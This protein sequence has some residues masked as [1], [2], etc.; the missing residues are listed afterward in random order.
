M[1]VAGLLV[2]VVVVAVGV[3]AVVVVLGMIV[4][5]VVAAGLVVV[6]LVVATVFTG[7]LVVREAGK[8]VRVLDMVVVLSV[9][10]IQVAMAGLLVA[11]VLVVR[12][13]VGFRRRRKLVDKLGR[14][15]GAQSTRISGHRGGCVCGR[16]F[17]AAGRSALEGAV[18]GV[19]TGRPRLRLNSGSVG[20]GGFNLLGVLL[21]DV[22]F[23][24][25]GGALGSHDCSH[26]VGGDRGSICL[27]AV[28]VRPY[29]SGRGDTGRG[30][31]SRGRRVGRRRLVRS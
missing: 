28:L 8:L 20:G 13:M 15:L 9:V 5:F 7:I 29:H 17:H 25:V 31:Q 12:G 19:D 10:G 26:V 3:P 2:V 6:L 22:L 14:G 11:V 27:G 16:R 1:V 23:L 24:A 4:V 30:M 21:V 18:F